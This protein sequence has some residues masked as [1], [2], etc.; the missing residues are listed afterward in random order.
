ML[1]TCS[2]LSY[3][4]LALGSKSWCD[5]H[6]T[7]EEAKAWGEVISCTGRRAYQLDGMSPW[8]Q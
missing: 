1:S 6:F 7:G 8:K 2:E 5:P 4:N 3:L